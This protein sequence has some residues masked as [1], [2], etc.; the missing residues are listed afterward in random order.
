MIHIR[1]R[2]SATTSTV[3]RMDTRWVLREDQRA[4]IPV[5]QY[6]TAQASHK[7]TPQREYDRNA[8]VAPARKATNVRQRVNQR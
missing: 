8:D 3:L 5:A 2:T 4:P 7:E 1:A 6:A